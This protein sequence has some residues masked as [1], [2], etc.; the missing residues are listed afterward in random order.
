MVAAGFWIPDVHAAELPGT[1]QMYLTMSNAMTASV[2]VV[3]P[4]SEIGIAYQN[5]MKNGGFVHPQNALL[6]ISSI[7]ISY[8][9]PKEFPGNTLP[10][11]QDECV[12]LT[13]NYT[14]WQM[15]NQGY[16]SIIENIGFC[17]SFPMN[18]IYFQDMNN[19]NYPDFNHP[20]YGSVDMMIRRGNLRINRTYTGRTTSP[21]YIQAYHNTIN[22]NDLTILEWGLHVPPE[23]GFF[24]VGNFLRQHTR[25]YSSSDP[26]ATIDIYSFSYTIEWIAG[27]WNSMYDPN[28]GKLMKLFDKYGNR[29]SFYEKK[30]WNL[31][32]LLE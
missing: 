2:E 4:E 7:N 26:L 8:E 18:G 25:D 17:L 6:H 19:S 16:E 23:T 24:T 30:V 14:S 10:Y 32:P 28:S 3:V 13:I 1:R 5:G 22:S 11:Y 27:T 12:K 15:Q 20:I 31:L 21:L 29:L 9:Y